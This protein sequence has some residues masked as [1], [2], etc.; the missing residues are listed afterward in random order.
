M[1]LKNFIVEIPDFPKKGVL[2]KDIT[3]IFLKPEAFNN[4][5]EWFLSVAEKHQVNKIS[6]IES[7]GFLFAAPVA[8]LAKL[9]LA[10]IRKRNKLPREKVSVTSYLEYGEEVLELHVDAIAAGDRVMIIDDVLATGGTVEAATKLICQLDGIVVCAGFLIELCYLNG[11]N[12]LNGLSVEAL[13]K[14]E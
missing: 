8:L 9:P 6:A 12:K 13:I 2:F 10:I 4:V 7:R 5:I 14:Y 3:P 1:D 11:R